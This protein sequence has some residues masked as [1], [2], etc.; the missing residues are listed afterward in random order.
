MIPPVFSSTLLAA[1][2]FGSIGMLAW[3]S[4]AVLP[5]LLHLWNRNQRR[6]TSWAAME[7]LLAAV[8]ERSQRMRLEQLLLLILRM[9]IPI[10]LALALADPLW[11]WLPSMGG[12]LGSRPPHHQMFVIDLS[13]S[14]G[15]MTSGE[16]RL[17]QVRR[18]AAEIVDGA[19]QGD[20]FTIV[21]I[22]DPSEVAVGVPVFS[23][24]DA[25]VE[26]NRLELRDNVADLPST[27]SLVKQTLLR[28]QKGFPRLKKHRIH[29]FSDLGA[30]T[31]NASLEP[32]VRNTIEE[33]ETLGD[34]VTYD[35]GLES[36]SNTG[37]VSVR[38]D[39]SVVTPQT[40]IG[41][42]VQCEQLAGVAEGPL[43][44]EILVDG[45]LAGRKSIEFS[46]A[47]TASTV[48]RHQFG[49]AGQY[50]VVFQIADDNLAVD[51]RYHEIVEVRD[52]WNL[53]C[54]EGKTAS[55]RNVA[56]AL[57]P[58]DDSSYRVR[59][60]PSHRLEE[61][62]LRNYD[63]VF[64][65]NPGRI[66]R[67]MATQFRDYLRLGRS[68]VFFLGDQAV[69]DNYNELLAGGDENA[70][71][72]PAQLN[73]ATSYATWRLAPAD[74][75]HPI[76]DVFRGQ[77]RS[78]LLTTPIWKYMRL[79]IP[80]SSSATVAL[81]FANGDPAIVEHSVGGGHVTLFA[82]PP[83]DKSVS[84]AQ[85]VPRPWTAWSSW[86]S[87][88]PLM[89]ETLAYSLSKQS[90]LRNVRVGQPIS[91]TLPETSSQRFVDIRKPNGMTQRIHVDEV[92]TPRWSFVETLRSGI[93]EAATEDTIETKK[94]AVNL[95]DTGEG[96]LER[97]TMDELPDQF[98]ERSVTVAP[99]GSTPLQTEQKPLF[100]WMLGLLLV[101][102]CTESF[103]AWYLGNAH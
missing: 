88:P 92:G 54:V 93:Y 40:R 16:T 45:K 98:R 3:A 81:E 51:N 44:V 57:A 61:I 100:R 7:F 70:P 101:L 38:R 11:N 17:E 94:F 102:L 8:Q 37:I 30:T 67:P 60:I 31:W 39:A 65:C 53:L 32:A 20:G 5:L 66:T 56:L 95:A 29:F 15:Y 77:E 52:Q 50:P 43:E 86:P 26:L 103:V 84:N 82:I 63:V 58:T 87:F 12:S 83:A 68:M 71:L 48:F 89:Q 46:S 76:I 6:E 33:I 72:L 24:D 19:P 69:P 22:S 79:T 42:Q 35:V 34:V 49:S 55:A 1:G 10:V 14:M 80:E 62:D 25:L 36:A 27:L 91:A 4:A 64:L 90:T 59:T 21:T 97:I 28:T 75:R 74:Y 18:M 41:W 2:I 85:G 9:A 13:W 47:S 23:A 73:E 99:N 96:K 78:G